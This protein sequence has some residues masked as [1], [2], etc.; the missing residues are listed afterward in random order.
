MT[1][2]VIR[3]LTAGEEPLF[4]TRSGTAQPCAN[5]HSV[6]SGIIMILFSFR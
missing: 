2:L 6:L 1:D 5:D 3:P 4:E